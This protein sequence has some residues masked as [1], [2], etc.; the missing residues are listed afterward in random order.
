MKKQ[1]D[2]LT[3]QLNYPVKLIAVPTCNV[4]GPTSS[5]MALN[6]QHYAMDLNAGLHL[7]GIAMTSAMSGQTEPMAGR[8]PGPPDKLFREIY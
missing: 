2:W 3:A 1:G 7:K 6:L 8:I 5:V 4:R